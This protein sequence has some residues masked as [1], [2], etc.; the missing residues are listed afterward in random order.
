MGPSG[1]TGGGGGPARSGGDDAGDSGHS[2]TVKVVPVWCHG[3]RRKS[4][5]KK[6]ECGRNDDDVDERTLSR[7]RSRMHSMQ[8]GE[9]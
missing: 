8:S 6:K 1:P 5:W 9:I 2:G 4:K 7:T 3:A